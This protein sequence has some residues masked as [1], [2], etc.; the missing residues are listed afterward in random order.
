MNSIN[1]NLHGN[2]FVNLYNYTWTNVDVFTC[3]FFLF[4]FFFFNFFIF[5][6]YS[7]NP[8]NQGPGTEPPEDQGRSWS[9]LPPQFLFNNIC[10]G[11]CGKIKCMYR[12][13]GRLKASATQT[14]AEGPLYPPKIKKGFSDPVLHKQKVFKIV[15]KKI[16]KIENNN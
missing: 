2:K 4:F 13:Q 10:S 5:Y 15:P 9:P 16:Q 6:F 12:V 7:Y 1:V 3:L 14:Q 11:V 8:S